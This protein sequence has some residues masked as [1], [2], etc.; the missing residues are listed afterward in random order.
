MRKSII[1][2]IGM[3]FFSP[4]IGWGANNQD[5]YPL[6]NMM[7]DFVAVPQGLT[8]PAGGRVDFHAMVG[9][10]GGASRTKASRN[11]N[12]LP[13][14]RV[15][16]DYSWSDEAR[17]DSSTDTRDGDIHL[18]TL[19]IERAFLDGL[20]SVEVRLPFVSGFDDQQNAIINRP[21]VQGSDFG[22]MYIGSKLLLHQ[23]ATE[24]L[25]TGVGFTLPTGNSTEFVVGAV[26]VASVDNGTGFI[27]P[28]VAYTRKQGRAFL[29]TWT[30]FDFA[31]GGND[32]NIA[33][34]QRGIYQEQNLFH[35][36]AQ[37]GFWMYRNRHSSGLI[38]GIA[39]LAELHYTSTLND[40]DAILLPPQTYENPFNRMDILTTTVGTQIDL[41]R[42]SSLRLGAALPLTDGRFEEEHVSNVTFIA[43]WDLIR[44]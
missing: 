27:Q 21:A 1:A 12:V 9:V 6:P 34:V 13:M 18:G 4:A 30:Q 35:F 41:G 20:F 42:F 28:Y 44:R 37:V 31:V 32:L 43:Q 29:Q 39:P 5:C 22:N 25:T 7:G 3:L 11:N 26:P 2:F 19:G 23:S 24:V 15:F 8:F 16:F 10:A 36:D 33:G 38:K 40:T 14:T 17:F